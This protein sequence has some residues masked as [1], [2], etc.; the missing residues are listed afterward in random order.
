MTSGKNLSA[1]TVETC[2]LCGSGDLEKLF[3]CED[4]LY[5]IPGIFALVR[6]L[7]CNL[8]RLS[9]RPALNDLP[10]YYPED[11]YH[12]YQKPGVSA[13]TVR[14]RGR[15]G[16]L[17]DAIRLSALRSLGYP[18]SLTSRWQ[19]A[20]GHMADGIFRNRALYGLSYRFPP[21]FPEGR[22]LDIGCGNGAY[23]SQGNR[24]I[25]S[26]IRWFYVQDFKQIASIPTGLQPLGLNAA[27]QCCF[28]L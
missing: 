6:C 5:R 7:G 24:P 18:V 15:L 21:Y 14:N 2:V 22:A 9:P 27:F 23:L 16:G 20:V 8:Y 1:E 10:H 17:R 13:L 4:R 25:T 3:C 26:G 11:G 19:S 28:L 12:S